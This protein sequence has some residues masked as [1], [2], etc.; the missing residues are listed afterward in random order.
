MT[1]PT[2]FD[3]SLPPVCGGNTPPTSEPWLRCK[4]R[5]YLSVDARKKQHWQVGSRVR[6]KSTSTWTTEAHFDK[7][8]AVS[9]P[10]QSYG[11]FLDLFYPQRD[12]TV[13]EERNVSK[14]NVDR[15]I[16]DSR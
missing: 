14:S 11:Y 4:Y 15:R 1:T 7:G 9:T 8:F 6:W 12:S 10:Q 5:M 13:D 2:S 3:M 16:V